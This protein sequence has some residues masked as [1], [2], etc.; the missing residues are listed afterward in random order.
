M[1][2]FA[3]VSRSRFA[4]V[5]LLAFF[6]CFS[7]AGCI[8]DERA[9][10]I[11]INKECSDYVDQGA[12]QLLTLNVNEPK[13]YLDG[14]ANVYADLL[15]NLRS[16]DTSGCSFEYKNAFEKFVAHIEK[17][18]N[19][20]QELQTLQRRIENGESENLVADANRM[21]E[22]GEEFKTL[23]EQV[24]PEMNKLTAAL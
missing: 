22:I 16:L 20:S 14:V 15:A 1:Q 12:V 11:K 7:F 21:I 6:A 4:L 9:Q 2:N 8:P 24:V 5:A 18:A 17:L 23:S 10:N 19:L 13:E 3:L